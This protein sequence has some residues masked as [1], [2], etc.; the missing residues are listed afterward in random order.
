MY[1]CTLYI[2]NLMI[3][4][5]Q[6]FTN[7]VLSDFQATPEICSKSGQFIMF[8]GAISS[9][10]RDSG[11]TPASNKIHMPDNRKKLGK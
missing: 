9:T 8:S 6:H 3:S 1:A 7:P 2:I 10:C 11:N 5:F 4:H